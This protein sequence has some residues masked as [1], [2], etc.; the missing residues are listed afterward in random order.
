MQKVWRATK[1]LKFFEL[2]SGLMLVEFEEICD[3]EKVLR[4]SPWSFDKCPIL[5]QEYD[6]KKQAEICE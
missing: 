3:K 6:G 2:G 5:L 1:P 4:D